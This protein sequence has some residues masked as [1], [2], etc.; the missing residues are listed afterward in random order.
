[1]NT[2]HKTDLYFDIYVKNNKMLFK[3]RNW[4]TIIPLISNNV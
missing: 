2:T 1:M 4:I 3:L